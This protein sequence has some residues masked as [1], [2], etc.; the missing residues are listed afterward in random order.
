MSRRGDKS[1]RMLVNALLPALRLLPPRLAA[2][3]VQAVGRTRYA[4]RSDIRR[5]VNSAVERTN[6]YFGGPWNARSVGRDLVGNTILW[7]MRDRLFDGRLDEPVSKLFD[8]IGRQHLDQALG[9]KRGVVLLCNHFGAHMHP[10]HWMAR[11]GYP[12]RLFMERPRTISRFLAKDFDSEGPT[13]QRKLF[14]SRKAK[15]AESAGAILRACGVIRSG[16]ALYIAGDVR[17]S[18]QLSLPV[19]FLGRRFSLSMT[20]VTLAAL[21]GAPV[22]PVFC[23]HQPDGSYQLEF[24]EG[25][26]VPKEDQQPQRAVPWVERYLRELENRV[27]RYPSNSNDYFFWDEM[28]ESAA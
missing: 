28:I 24:L 25:F 5:T 17:W 26:T 2:R 11:N 12:L 13:G 6:A 16:A 18:G 1:N 3:V 10:A 15:P 4:I 27:R 22:V 20:W 21:T 14:I 9:Q 23:V 19:T 8:V 7:Q